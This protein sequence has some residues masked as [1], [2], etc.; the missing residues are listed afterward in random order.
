MLHEARRHAHSSLPRDR[1]DAT[2]YHAVA[3]DT[4]PHRLAQH[5]ASHQG[6]VARTSSGCYTHGRT[7]TRY[8]QCALIRLAASMKHC[9]IIREPY[10]AH[11]SHEAAR[12]GS[13]YALGSRVR[14]R[15]GAA[16]W[17]GFH[18]QMSRRGSFFLREFGGKG[19]MFLMHAYN[20]L[21]SLVST[22][23]ATV[24]AECVTNG[25]VRFLVCCA[26]FALSV[27]LFFQRGVFFSGPC[28][29]EHLVTSFSFDLSL[30]SLNLNPLV[31]L[32]F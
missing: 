8:S 16:F 20:S 5:K 12:I 29:F 26:T 4:K 18:R 9:S 10:Q 27:S 31:F 21:V 7:R 15:V 17:R 3:R 1:H 2:S 32:L 25:V 14:L 6:R 11:S 23:N 19:Q 30:R 13:S 24:N 28:L 22:C